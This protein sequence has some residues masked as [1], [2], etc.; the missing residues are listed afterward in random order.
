MVHAFATLLVD[1]RK[2]PRAGRNSFR[3]VDAAS[4][5][6]QMSTRQQ[7]ASTS[8]QAYDVYK[9][10]YRL[11]LQDPALSETRYHTAIFVH[12]DADGAGF[13]HEVHGDIAS[14]TGMK[15]GRKHE[16]AP[17][18]SDTFHAKTL[19]GKVLANDYPGPVEALLHTV[20]P[21]PR[22]KRFDPASMSW[23][24]CKSDGTPYASHET[25]PPYSKC[26]E[27]TEQR[28][29]PALLR[30]GLIHQ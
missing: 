21:P 10:Q 14:G 15:Y 5:R 12:T 27:W 13:I 22:Q 7:E 29:I 23:E 17:E 24:Q 28:A 20:P 26:T 1:L 8:A 6:S 16:E 3:S 2:T 18:L 11:G 4:T 25:R 9:V 19:L 30:A